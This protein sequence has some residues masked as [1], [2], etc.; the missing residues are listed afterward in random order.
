M[1]ET[2]EAAEEIKGKI[3]LEYEVLDGV[4]TIDDALKDEILVHEGRSN[5]LDTE[6]VNRGNVDKAL[7]ES[8]YVYEGS[9]TTP[10]TEHAFMEPE[11]AV[12]LPYGDGVSVY[13]GDQSIYDDSDC[14]RRKYVSTPCL[15]AAASEARRTCPCSTMPRWQRS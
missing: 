10:F 1:A 15:S 11:C 12:A 7:R 14:R 5:L 2:R 3:R 9:F 8:D 6:I 13:A 4:Y